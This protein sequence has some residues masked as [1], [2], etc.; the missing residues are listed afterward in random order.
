MSSCLKGLCAW[1]QK[2]GLTD[3]DQP[4][5][6]CSVVGSLKTK[7][8]LLDFFRAVAD[9]LI[10]SWGSSC[11]KPMLPSEAWVESMPSI[12]HAH[13]AGTGASDGYRL[14]SCVTKQLPCY[15]RTRKEQRG[16]RQML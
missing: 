5:L 1:S 10:Q 16:R 14:L 9:K 7:A 13:N 8:R 4:C 3:P 15:L 2:L 11:L 12:S 6:L